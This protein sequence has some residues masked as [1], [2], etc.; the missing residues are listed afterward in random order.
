M[1][2]LPS[3]VTEAVV[4]VVRTPL[5]AVSL[6]LVVATLTTGDHGSSE[7]GDVDPGDPVPWTSAPAARSYINWEAGAAGATA[8]DAIGRTP[9]GATT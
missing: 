6:T 2:V 5:A 3:V 8:D 4:M 7:S 9:P 1:S